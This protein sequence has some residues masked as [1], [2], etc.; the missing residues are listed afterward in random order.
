MLKAIE[1][2]KD[3]RGDVVTKEGSACNGATGST[4][5]K[6]RSIKIAV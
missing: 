1:R 5:R 4:E 6:G 3:A 2:G